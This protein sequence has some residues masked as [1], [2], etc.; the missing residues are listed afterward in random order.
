MSLQINSD[1]QII[2]GSNPSVIGTNNYTIRA[3]EGA[4]QKEIFRAQ[5]SNTNLPRIGINRTGERIERIQVNSGG[6][7]YNTAPSVTLGP[8]NRTGGVQATASAIVANG[9][10][11]FITVDNPGNGYDTAPSVTI[12]AQPGDPGAGAS[13]VAFLDTVDFELDVSGAIR[14][15]TSI[16]SDTARVL[17]LDVD[18]FVTPDTAFRGPNLKTY[19]NNTGVLWVPNTIIVHSGDN[20]YRYY[21]DNI[22]QALNTGATGTTPPTHVDGIVLNGAVQLKHIGF[23]VSRPTEPYYNT[24]GNSGL[25]PRSI[26][27]LQGDRSDKIATTEYVLN[28]A[29]NDVGGRVYVSEQI[30]DDDNDGRSAV[31]PV[32][33]IKRACQIAQ[34]TVG[35]K[36][37]VIIAG[38]EY[39]EDNPISIP[40]DC[41][42]IGDNLRLVIV[43]PA[44]ANKHFFKLSD[45]NYINGITFR[46]LVDS[47]NDPVHTWNYA[48]VFDDK[49]RV[50]YDPASGGDF[51]RSWPIGHQFFG[52]NKVRIPFNSNTGGSNLTANRDLF[53]TN[54]FARGI[55]TSVTFN[56]VSGPTAYQSGV[57][58]A[59]VTTIDGFDQS[60]PIN[61]YVPTFFTPT[62]VTYNPST[63]IAIITIANHGF[64]NGSLIKVIN[65]S[66]SF[67][68]ASD[69]NTTTR[70]FPRP[71]DTISGVWLG[72]SNVSTNTFQVNL[73]VS[74]DTSARTFVS[75]TSNA[76]AY[77][78]AT[79]EFTSIVPVSIRAEGEVT[80]ELKN[81]TTSYPITMVDGSQQG[82]FNDGFQSTYFGNSENLGGIVVQTA[83][84]IPGRIGFHEFKEG[85]IVRIAGLTGLLSPL[86]G[87]QRIY[88]VIRDADGRS[89]RFVIPKI[90]SGFTGTS[91]PV[92][93]TVTAYTNYVT[94][95]LLN[96]PNKLVLPNPVSR[97]FQDACTYIRNNL[98]FISDETVKQINDEFAQ[99]WF[100]I[101]N[102]SGNSFDINTQPNAFAHTYVNGGTVTFNNN[103]YT[104]TAFTYNN[105]TGVGTITTASAIG[106]VNGNVVK[107][108]NL[109]ISCSQ[110]EK[111]YPGFNIPN[112]DAKCYRDVKHFLNSIVMDL[113]FGGNYN[114][115]E[116]AERYKIG[117]QIGYISNEITETVRAFQIATELAILAM[118]NWRTGN[119]TVG[120][121]TYIPKYSSIARYFDDTVITATAGSPACAN[122]A[123]AITTLSY[124]F[125]DIISNNSTGT[126]LDA[127]YLI[128]KNIDLIADEAL[129]FAKTSFPTLSLSYLDESKCKRDIKYIL[130]SL[131]RDLVLGG[132]AGIVT[133]AELYFT[134]SLLTGIP[135]AELVPTITAFNKARDLA[136]QSTRNWSN[137]TVAT[138]TPTN[139][140]YNSTT[141]VLNVTFA[142]PTTPVT[143]SHRIAFKEGAITFS[144]PSNGGG[145]LASPTVTD[146]NYG[147]SLTITNVSIAGGNTTVTV[148]VG[149]AGTAT[150]VTHTFV[151]A[152]ANGTIIVYD[153]VTTFTSPVTKY[154]NWNILLSGGT[155]CANVASTIT[156]SFALLE[157]ILDGTIAPGATTK[158]YGTSYTLQPT[159]P[160]NVV[161]DGSGKFITPLGFYDDLPVI[162][163]SPYIQN[164]SIISFAG[165]SGC[166]IDGDKV[167]QPNSPRPGLEDD[168]NNPGGTP[169]AAF[170]NQGKS[171][172]ASAFTIVSFGGTGYRVINDGYCQL[173][174]VF[175]IFC[176]DGVLSESGGYASITNSATNFGIYAL[177]AIGFSRDPYQFDIGTVSNV[178]ATVGTGRTI[179]TVSGLGRPPLE[180]Y[181]V[182]FT[183]YTN[184]NPAIEYFIESID[185]NSISVSAPYTATFTVN[186]AMSLKRKSD[187]VVVAPSTAELGGKAIQL[188]RPSI[189]NSSGHTWEYAGS[190]TNY[191][192]LPENGGVKI[193]AYEQVSQQY[194]RVYTSGTDELG[195]FK[196]GTFAKIENRTGAITFTG[197]VSISEVEF[198]KLKG[199][200]VVVTGFDSSPTLGG[201]FSSDEK[202]PTQK[203]VRDY[204]TN[205]LGQYIN[206]PFSTNAVP[207]ALVELT[208]SGKI[209]IDQI[210]AL[211][212]FSVYTVANVTERL[213]IEGALAGDI[214]IQQDTSTS[215]ILNNDLDSLYFAYP[216]TL[217]DI[218]GNP[219]DFNTNS[220]LTGSGTTGQ[221]Q[222]L[223]HRRGVVYTI[224]ITNPGSGYTSAPAVVISGGSPG[225]GSVAAFATTTIANGQVVTVKLTLF[226]GYVGGKG[227]TA[228]PT[229]TIAAPGAGGTQATAGALVENRVYGKVVNNLKI[230][231]TD[232]IQSNDSPSV[233]VDIT[234]V[235]NTS[236]SNVN[237]WVSLSSQTISADNITEGIISPARLSSDSTAA[238]SFTFLRGDQS[239]APVVQS[240][241]GTE[242]RY[243]EITNTAASSSSNTLRFASTGQPLVGHTVVANVGGIPAN[244]TIQSIETTGG[245]TTITL[246]NP[247]T[248]SIPSGTVIE[249]TRPTSP[250]LF[251]TSFTQGS[252]VESA[253]VQNGGSGFSSNGIYYNVQVNGGT[254]TGLKANFTITSGSISNVVITSS[255]SGYT[256]DFGVNAIPAGL[257]SGGSGINILFKIN[258][259][260]KNYANVAMDIRR[261]DAQTINADPYGRAGVGRFDKSQFFL[262]LD[263]DGSVRL[264]TGPGSNLNA[265]KLDNEE[266]SYYLNSANQNAGILPVDRLSGTYRISITGKK[267]GGADRLTTLTTNSTTSPV[268]SDIKEGVTAATRDNTAD[269][270]NVAG[271]KHLVLSIRNGGVGTDATYGGVRQLAFADDNSMYL[272]GTGS[273][274]S[275]FGSW[276]KIW[277]SGNHGPGSGLDADRLDGRQGTWYRNGL[278]LNYGTIIDR[279]LP[280]FQEAKQF[281]DSITIREITS[282]PV[283]NIYI[284]GQA[285]VTDPFT[286][287]SAVNLYNDLDQNVGNLTI[288]SVTVNNVTDPT[289]DYT[290]LN[291]VLTNG[292][293]SGATRVGT[294]ATSVPFDDYWLDVVG[295]F[296]VA[297]LASVSGGTARLTMGRNNGVSTEPAIYFRTSA[298][299]AS[300]YNS[301]IIARGG[302]APDGSGI[303]E[304]KVADPNSLLVNNLT[305]WNSGNI[306][307]DNGNTPNTGVRRDTNGN[308]T[309][310]TI[311]ANLTGAASANVLKAGDTMTGSLTLTGA[312]SNLIVGGTLGV[313]GNATLT[314]SLTVDTNTL[315]VNSTSDLVGVGLNPSTAATTNSK[316]QVFSGA[317]GTTAGNATYIASFENTSSNYSRLLVWQRRHTNGADWTTSSTRI[318][319]RIDVTDQAYIEFNPPGS[320]FGLALGT[321][322][323]SRI[324]VDQTGLVGIGKSAASGFIFDAAGKGR[325]EGGLELDT[326][327]D[328]SGTFV[329][330]LGAST[331][332]NFRIGHELTNANVFEINPSTTNGGSTFTVPGL[333]VKAPAGAVTEVRVGIGVANPQYS[334]DVNGN[335]NFSG[336]ITANGATLTSSNWTKATNTLDIY[337]MSKV[338]VNKV[339]PQYTLDVGGEINL[340]GVQRVNGDPLWLDAYGV[341]RVTRNLISQ[342]VIIPSGTNAQS[343]GPLIIQ[344]GFSVTVETGGAWTIV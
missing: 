80:S 257:P 64:S 104:V 68:H 3:G 211:R 165:G 139:A 324:V 20:P 48:V 341:I 85:E 272:R 339:N 331:S 148:N 170:P 65:D 298:L 127:G 195:D 101:S 93:A 207:R 96:S 344:S 172:V 133:A 9:S 32:R 12:T 150:G 188:H 262:G 217:T 2:L 232:T 327:N 140:T 71:T 98:D 326:A 309:A 306:T 251:D 321:N 42:I 94:L 174:S 243:F 155:L 1:K 194:G 343:T 62:N 291:V 228:V 40:P 239:F 338:G 91:E 10:V 146:R 249:F 56:A 77:A 214:A 177:R 111:L 213:A 197:T 120:N 78:A 313:T 39:V 87:L 52:A 13:A 134:G 266:G 303:L 315:I 277:S 171:M 253:I 233:A 37:T 18:N 147:N 229:V 95:T 164:S 237:N 297:K 69:G 204:I 14:T 135:S 30:G 59:T 283:F 222:V 300:N 110:G 316:L 131:R 325:F 234:R 63:G 254:G 44:N 288:N 103:T 199:G 152:L 206:K 129:R 187:N 244:T 169:R 190:G 160:D 274:V 270:L 246:N 332:K 102:V 88:K 6:A 26:T 61:Y 292:G 73:G 53:G 149:D 66:L 278:N 196:V 79:Y 49:Q 51:G 180:H 163:A 227:Y 259:V 340:T 178:S 305:I 322:S 122:V 183:D 311:T 314:G 175:V 230:E 29:T 235:V 328:N 89:R 22:Y 191:N 108:E 72:V 280:T 265:D 302:N 34:A 105:V 43:R 21:G 116:A 285:L 81:R 267:E 271:S 36:E 27:P 286:A 119:G 8:P 128:A 82:D 123:S 231:D 193:E 307:F 15:S 290:I 198:L 337:R 50:Y 130:R 58:E 317:L 109:L 295:T 161:G 260:S 47:N 113:E 263:G 157:D 138:T 308:F 156:N 125:V 24:S 74:T 4:N 121:P 54:S 19:A 275:N 132:N 238:N 284:S 221:L 181:I 46:D 224:N 45:K 166:E 245:N 145:N 38:G 250:L 336:T 299:A 106:A 205:N 107:V 126:Y 75:A 184:N 242:T 256:S 219:L 241:K 276:A 186:E 25:F 67:T 218:N 99:K 112:G 60:E 144:C 162:E 84:L 223:E 333:T 210:P 33:T 200:T 176:T 92:G 151:S 247:L 293:F 154:E 141:G 296:E 118:R 57:V 28:L 90:I 252:F 17:N 258:T 142:N 83:Q 201:A 70:T 192:A 209:S 320:T 330:F 225:A 7:L 114:V 202:L 240:V 5:L 136:I 137:G 167:Q 319:Q 153:P 179:L 185:K 301:A 248:A 158:T 268:P 215:Y 294:T 182:K 76:I 117:T 264:K 289:E 23:R 216:I 255:G 173:V 208:D 11:T 31:A 335:V 143:T 279:H 115:V 318:Q 189:V 282:Q 86:N 273:G 97:R 100:T 261:V 287:T 159:Y 212:P 323:I 342:N 41:S 236:A 312:S 124:A 304:F 329:T 281:E 16:I 310:G 226:N 220:I 203:A 55:V 168:P 35:I 269:G 334:L